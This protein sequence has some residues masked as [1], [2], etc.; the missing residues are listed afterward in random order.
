MA[1]I[2]LR[3]TQ[4]E[5]GFGS[6]KAAFLGCLNEK[7]PYHNLERE[8]IEKAVRSGIY[9][10]FVSYRS[11]RDSDVRDRVVS[12]TAKKLSIVLSVKETFFVMEVF[13]RA[14]GWEILIDECIAP[15]GNSDSISKQS[16]FP[17]N[18]EHIIKRHTDFL[19]RI[20]QKKREGPIYGNSDSISKQPSSPANDEH[21]IKQISHLEDGMLKE[22]FPFGKSN[23]YYSSISG[24]RDE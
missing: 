18:V 8:T 10:E 22:L 4:K 24:E 2:A 1:A 19:N 15:H 14:I 21:I 5:L 6:D 20:L 12:E 16:S 17:G 3:K 7:L 13:C 23:W 11:E 9:K